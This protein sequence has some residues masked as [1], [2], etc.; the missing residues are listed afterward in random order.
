MA[1]E[2]N[3][4]LVG[5]AAPTPNEKE[6]NALV[7]L[8]PAN[9]LYAAFKILEKAANTKSTLPILGTVLFSPVQPAPG[10][11][12]TVAWLQATRLDASAARRVPVTLTW[13]TESDWPDWTPPVWGVCLPVGFLK[14]FS[15]ARRDESP[16]IFRW[17]QGPIITWKG[18]TQRIPLKSQTGDLDACAWDVNEFPCILWRDQDDI[19]LLLPNN[20]DALAAALKAS[21]PLTEDGN[22]RPALNGVCL[23]LN[24]SAYRLALKGG[25]IVMDV[26]AADGFVL[27][28]TPLE[29]AARLDKQP[30]PAQTQRPILNKASAALL[31]TVLELID[32]PS[33]PCALTS[34]HMVVFWERTVLE[35]RLIDER[36]PEYQR[37]LPVQQP[38]LRTRIDSP[39]LLEIINSL[40][41]PGKGKHKTL[42]ILGM[43]YIPG[44]ATNA[45]RI[46]RWD[47]D[48][49]AGE[50]ALP[51][52]HDDVQI[53]SSLAR[54]G[55]AIYVDGN[56]LRRCLKSLALVHQGDTWLN[57]FID[58]SFPSL[59]VTGSGYPT[60]LRFVMGL[61]PRNLSSMEPP[62]VEE[63]EEEEESAAAQP[64]PQEKQPYVKTI[65]QA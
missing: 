12:E 61:T 25:A 29:G 15:G 65:I 10:Q 46:R 21:L 6:S 31:A 26:A 16:V 30:W 19:T 63:E 23:S 34:Q 39:R 4:K 18:I 33:V 52:E 37:I 41:P 47:M 64:L 54:R 28:V 53:M 38:G 62:P 42:F 35:L 13:D 24:P 59:L 7:Y 2:A 58:S 44:P 55:G 5:G 11:R 20:G 43:V 50:A 17:E 9:E 49:I 8:I 45:L 51:L 22:T 48:S 36:F 40:E 60:P 27:G 3:S 56:H 14:Q 32:A 1:N 57:L